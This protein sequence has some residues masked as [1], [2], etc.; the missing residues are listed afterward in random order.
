MN[1]TFDLLYTLNFV[2]RYN[3]DKLFKPNIF[4]ENKNTF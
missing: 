4:E 1:I 3:Y 2:N